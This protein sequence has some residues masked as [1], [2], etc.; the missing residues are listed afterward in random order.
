MTKG[1]G[2]QTHPINLGKFNS[3]C[4][5]SS[6]V[7]GIFKTEI[8]YLEYGLQFLFKVCH[9]LFR[10][11]YTSGVPKSKMPYFVLTSFLINLGTSCTVCCFI[12]SAMR[13][14]LVI[15]NQVSGVVLN[16]DMNHEKIQLH[17]TWYGLHQNFSW[18]CRSRMFDYITRNGS[19]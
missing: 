1:W 17:E 12:R 4:Q 7:D 19:L 8:S 2:I 13:C 10:I 14:A 9:C 16:H 11:G 15:K 3:N 18:R 6:W 5:V